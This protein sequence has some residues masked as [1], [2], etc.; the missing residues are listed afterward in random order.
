MRQ[1]QLVPN[2]Q[3][4]VD[5]FCNLPQHVRAVLRLLLRRRL[6]LLILLLC[7][8]RPPLLPPDGFCRLHYGLPRVASSSATLVPII[9]CDPCSLPTATG[10]SR[11]SMLTTTR[12]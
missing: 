5:R 7:L 12:G 10:S 3:F 8:L 2:T 6:P 9:L 11:T 1:W 4:V